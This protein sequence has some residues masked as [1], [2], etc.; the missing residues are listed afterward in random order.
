MTQLCLDRSL[1]QDEACRIVDFM[2]AA[3]LEADA[4]GRERKRLAGRRKSSD[5]QERVNG[6]SSTS[7]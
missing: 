7:F 3:M 4:L 6:S 5:S 2:V 1:G